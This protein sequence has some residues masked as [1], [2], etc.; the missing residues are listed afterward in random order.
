MGVPRRSLGFPGGAEVKN[1]AASA[2]DVGL[3]PGLGR[4]PGG[5]NGNPLF[6][7]YSSLGNP[8][9]R[10]VWQATV[11]RV[12]NSLMAEHAHKHPRAP[13]PS[14]HLPASPP[15]LVPSR[16]PAQGP[17]PR[18]EKKWTRNQ[19]PVTT[20]VDRAGVQD[21]ARDHI[22]G[23]VTRK[24]VSF[25]RAEATSE[26]IL[27]RGHW[28]SVCEG[29]Q[30]TEPG[31]TGEAGKR[32]HRSPGASGASCSVAKSYLTLRPHGLQHTRLPCPSLSPRVCSNSCPLNR[33]LCLTTSSS[34]T[35]C[36]PALNLSQDQ[37]LFQ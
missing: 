16:V 24:R 34:D 11:H 33:F 19:D 12:T 6:S 31:D 4:S 37:G 21:C 30:L 20:G 9:E 7:R 23:G 3:I 5:G 27:S 15:G 25:V 14:R 8:M 1:P 18:A 35:P 2:G 29:A 13:V 22:R 32:A 26:A 28:A 10:G 36:P 17:K